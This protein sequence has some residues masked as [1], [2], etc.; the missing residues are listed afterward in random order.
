LDRNLEEK[1]VEDVITD[2]R[3]VRNDIP[4]IIMTGDLDIPSNFIEEYNISE[5]IHKPFQFDEFIKI[6]NNNL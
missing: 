6:V 5:V 4:I 2:L 1:S 3:K